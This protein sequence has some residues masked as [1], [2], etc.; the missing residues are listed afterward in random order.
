MAGTSKTVRSL[1][2]ACG[3]APRGDGLYVPRV[4][5]FADLAELTP[6]LLRMSAAE[7]AGLPGVSVAR[8]LAAGALVL[9]AVLELSG[10]DELSVC[11]WRC[12]RAS[13]CVSWTG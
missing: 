13:S 9:E 1:A 11:P 5:R 7:R 10:V 8:Q 3:A 12:A 4:L 6:R 2:R